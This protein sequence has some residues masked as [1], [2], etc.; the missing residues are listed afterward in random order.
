MVRV[1]LGL[2]VVALLAL[3]VLAAA[4]SSTEAP[5]PP[6]P[7]PIN[8][9]E[10]IQQT[11]QAQPQGLTAQDVAS[12]I[13]NAMAGQ[14]GVTQ[15]DVAD[16]IASAMAQQQGVTPSDVAMAV[17]QAMASQPGVTQAEVG[18]AIAKA[19]ATQPGITEAQVADAIAGAMSGQQGVSPADVSDA[20]TK[21]LEA[22][23]GVTQAD[24]AAAVESA[25]AKAAPAAMAP[26]ADD[27]MMMVEE[28][29]KYGGTL[30]V[31]SQASIKSL[32]PD[33]CTS[34]VCWAPS[35]G[36][37]LEPL[38]TQAADFSTQPML[39]DSWDV[40]DDGNTWTL[41]LREGVKFHDGTPLT[42][43]AAILSTKRVLNDTPAG[44]VLKSFLAEDGL[45][46]VDDLT[47][48]VQTTEPYGS[49]LDGFALRTHGNVL[50]YTPTAAAFPMTEDVGEENIIGT[51][52]YMLE[53]WDVGV[54]VTLARNE[55]YQSRSEPGSWMA[56]GKKAYLDKIEWLEIPS[57]ETKVAG[58][59]TGE[60]DFI[61]SI[62]LDFVAALKED[63]DVGFT[64]YPGHMWY[65][66]FNVSEEPMDNLLLRKAIQAS[67]SGEDM[68]SA[69][70]PPD[71]WKLNCSIYGSG[72]VF[73][74]DAG[75][76]LYNQ[77][78]IARA[79]ELLAE[80]GYAGEP[81][82]ILNPTDYSTIT[83]VG[84]VIKARME[85]VGI[86]V[87]MPGMDWAT[88]TSKRL[89][90]EGWHIFTSW[91]TIQNRQNPALS[92]LL[93][94]GGKSIGFGYYNE[95]L[96]ELHDKFLRATDFESQKMIADDMQR[97]F[98]NNPPQVYSGI[99]F[100]PSAYRTWVHDVPPEHPGTPY[101][102]NVWMSR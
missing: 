31:V 4:C 46:I 24:I 34:Y 101:Y 62:G 93:A 40:S 84:P 66:G 70:G 69:I 43:E 99:F 52:P 38:M 65:F 75:C 7:T 83:P 14:Q 11:M 44:E 51:G 29:D 47:F 87:D 60:W 95:E 102:A 39:L 90:G 21:A 73:E 23:P 48:S 80:S 89:S 16:A 20:I 35:A 55:D 37:L 56:G 53:N 63:P 49:L 9:A 22:R 82:V 88:A 45:Q 41:N 54:K 1:R 91:G 74:S 67:M 72:T 15:A 8:V 42:S 61:D 32:D 57:E 64:W 30:R 77:N 96:H 13:Q 18:E 28:K 25:V 85:E 98:L 36:H 5:A 86:N 10:I 71:T 76:E 68:L 79:K 3:S 100:M 6:T 27:S 50:V 81:I 17:Q 19:L 78:N 33:F 94:G 26:A 58:L 92:F 12:E 97:S 2:I 59:K